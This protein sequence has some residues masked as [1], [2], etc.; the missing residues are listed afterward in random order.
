MGMIAHGLVPVACQKRQSRDYQKK[1]N[2]QGEY[3]I[4]LGEVRLEK[5]NVLE[6][7]EDSPKK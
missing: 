2:G 1:K 7:K 4:F 3:P 6:R 5:R